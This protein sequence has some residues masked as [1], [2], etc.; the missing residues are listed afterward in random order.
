MVFRNTNEDNSST[1]KISLKIWT[2]EMKNEKWIICTVPGNKIW[3]SFLIE[4]FE[5][6][7]KF[8]KND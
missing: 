5:I 8:L 3:P 7:K 2:E 4:I 1:R 6:F